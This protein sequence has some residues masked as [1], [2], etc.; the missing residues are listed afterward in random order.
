MEQISIVRRRSRVWPI[1]IVL[2]IVALV[3]AAAMFFF[4]DSSYLAAV[5]N[6]SAPATAVSPM[7]AH[8]VPL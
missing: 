6:E 2:I 5:V 7:A 4:G 3:V 1:V 8:A